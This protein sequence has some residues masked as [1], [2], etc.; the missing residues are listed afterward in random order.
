MA[1]DIDIIVNT[2]RSIT[3]VDA[4]VRESRVAEDGGST[5]SGRQYES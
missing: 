3:S 4:N 2:G 1:L 5:T